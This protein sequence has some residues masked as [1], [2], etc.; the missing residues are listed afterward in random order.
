METRHVPF[1]IIENHATIVLQDEYAAPNEPPPCY[2]QSQLE[3]ATKR[4]AR[5]EAAN[6]VA[7][8]QVQIGE[9]TPE[10]RWES[11]WARRVGRDLPPA[12]T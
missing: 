7:N 8:D 1:P 4:A 11:V 10:S 6:P 5:R 3:E 9:T 12:P 2:V